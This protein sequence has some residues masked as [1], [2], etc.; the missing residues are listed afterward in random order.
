M[1]QVPRY[2]QEG[3]FLR[4]SLD[5]L[6]V[7][8]LANPQLETPLLVSRKPPQHPPQLVPGKGQPRG[9]IDGC[10]KVVYANKD[11]G[12]KTRPNFSVK[13]KPPPASTRFYVRRKTNATGGAPFY[14]TTPPRAMPIKTGKRNPAKF[15]RQGKTFP[16]T[17][18]ISHASQT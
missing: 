2:T 6:P 3:M 15:F 18:R 5:L 9:T 14:W 13:E 11:R 7:S 10:S 16:S 1:A 4:G 12:R 8:L 17:H